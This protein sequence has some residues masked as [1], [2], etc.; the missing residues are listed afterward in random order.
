MAAQEVKVQDLTAR[1]Q[2]LE[3]SLQREQ[4]TTRT[5]EQ[6]V[7]GLNEKLA[8]TEKARE[9]LKADLAKSQEVCVYPLHSGGL[10]ALFVEVS[11]SACGS[12]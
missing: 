2:E 7:S 10:I 5:L 3:L 9:H 11:T 12:S 4:H 1:V 8:E 6:Q